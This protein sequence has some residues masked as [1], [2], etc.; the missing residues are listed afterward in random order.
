MM[1]KGRTSWAIPGGHI[2]LA[3]TGREPEYNS[4]DR[5]NILNT[6]AHQADIQLTI[7]YADRDPVGPYPLTVPGKRVRS[8]RFNDLIDPQAMP[9]DTDYACVLESSVPVIVQF[10][11]MDTSQAQNA[12]ASL[13][14]FP[15]SE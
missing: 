13:M 7:Y 1:A 11:R 10:T 4:H 15:L 9:L 14:A 8:I 3:S 6:G 5:I 12:I 2:P